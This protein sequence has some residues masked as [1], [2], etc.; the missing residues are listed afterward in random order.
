MHR[1][2]AY[3]SSAVAFPNHPS[4]GR[5]AGQAAVATSKLT[6]P[7]PL[8]FCSSRDGMCPG[9]QL[10]R[11]DVQGAVWAHWPVRITLGVGS[12]TALAAMYTGMGK[13]VGKWG[14]PALVLILQGQYRKS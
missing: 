5:A 2:K 8:S 3:Y 11:Q 7:L 6:A 9:L 12:A 10:L 13:V 4:F 14:R 1:G